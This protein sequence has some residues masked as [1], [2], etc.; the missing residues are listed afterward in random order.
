MQHDQTDAPRALDAIAHAIQNKRVIAATY[1]GA[2]IELCQHEL[3]VRDQSMFLRAFN[4]N[5]SRRHD[6]EPSLGKF[7]IAGMSEVTLS[8]R[9]F[10]PLPSFGKAEGT[11]EQSIV[12]VLD[13]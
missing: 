13:A 2:R 4:P 9:M 3:F 8:G 5:K 6:E 7:N 10:T 12:S 1:N 11:G